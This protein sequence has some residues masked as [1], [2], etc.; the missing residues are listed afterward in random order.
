[1]NQ[2][3]QRNYW[4]THPGQSSPIGGSRFNE[5]IAYRALCRIDSKFLIPSVCRHTQRGILD[6]IRD[7]RNGGGNKYVQHE[8]SFSAVRGVGWA[9]S[10]LAPRWSFRPIT[11]TRVRLTTILPLFIPR[12]CRLKNVCPFTP[13]KISPTDKACRTDNG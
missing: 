10:A 2:S 4:R 12:C 8:T 6:I 1:M 9:A 3:S 13:N 5:D 7:A 11:P